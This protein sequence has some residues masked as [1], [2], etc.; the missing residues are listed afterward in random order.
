MNKLH[1]LCLFKKRMDS[2]GRIYYSGALGNSRLLLFPSAEGELMFY[3]GPAL[4]P[5]NKTLQDRFR[6]TIGNR[7][8][9]MSGGNC[10]F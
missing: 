1:F 5:E 7:I 10:K 4:F 3:L 2:S 8:G 6:G 9:I